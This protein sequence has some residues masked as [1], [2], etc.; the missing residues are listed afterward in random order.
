MAKNKAP[1]LN[2]QK[3]ESTH[4]NYKEPLNARWFCVVNGVTYYNRTKDALIEHVQRMEWNQKN[5][6][7]KNPWPGNKP[8]GEEAEESEESD[9]A[10]K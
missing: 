6:P 7:R 10:A 1:D 5:D 8:E 3:L 4:S 9:E 2:I